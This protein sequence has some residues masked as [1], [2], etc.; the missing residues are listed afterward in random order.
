MDNTNPGETN[1]VGEERMKESMIGLVDRMDE[2]KE[3]SK[4]NPWTFETGR[5]AALPLRNGTAG[6]KCQF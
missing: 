2:E 1:Q 4:I 5:V 3:E 6:K